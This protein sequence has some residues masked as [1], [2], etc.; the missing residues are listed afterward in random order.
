LNK[1]LLGLY[2]PQTGMVLRDGQSVLP[3]G[4][5]DYGQ[6]FTTVLSGYYLF[7][8]VIHGASLAKKRSRI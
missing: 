8:D 1:L 6:L 4:R 5:D 7:D 3:G 2:A